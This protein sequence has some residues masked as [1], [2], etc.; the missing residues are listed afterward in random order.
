MNCVGWHLGEST[1]ANR[2]VAYSLRRNEVTP[3]NQEDHWT[4]GQYQIQSGQ[5]VHMKEVLRT[6][7]IA[8]RLLRPIRV[9]DVG[10]AARCPWGNRLAEVGLAWRSSGEV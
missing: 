8:R 3:S 2:D 9:R 6:S 5:V 4:V 10:D 1:Q 7:R